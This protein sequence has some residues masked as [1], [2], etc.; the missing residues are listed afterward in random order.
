MSCLNSHLLLIEQLGRF[1]MCCIYSSL[2]AFFVVVVIFVFYL[3]KLFEK[4]HMPRFEANIAAS[5]CEKTRAR[6]MFFRTA[7]IPLS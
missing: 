2:C 1:S 7:W 6:F 5:W 3:S 4:N